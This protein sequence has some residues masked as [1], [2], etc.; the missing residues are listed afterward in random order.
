MNAVG[1]PGSYRFTQNALQNV[2]TRDM[3]KSYR[4]HIKY[5]GDQ[6]EDFTTNAIKTF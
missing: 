4:S 3:R 1:E 2:C 6:L 5:M